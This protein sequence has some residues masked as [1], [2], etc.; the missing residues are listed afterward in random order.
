M[1]V[2][3]CG[4]VTPLR[5]RKHTRRSCCSCRRQ[6]VCFS[7]GNLLNIV[8]D[9]VGHVSDV[10]DTNLEFF[11]LFRE[12]VSLFLEGAVLNLG[13]FRAVRSIALGKSIAKRRLGL[14]KIVLTRF[15]L[16]LGV[17]ELRLGVRELRLGVRELRLGLLEF[18]LGI[19]ELRLLIAESRD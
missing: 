5:A 16:R 18:H 10:L 2:V 13:I 14:G 11:V 12:H 19:R 15:K 6:D 8:I 3:D 1:Q 17:R 9:H 4:G 7:L